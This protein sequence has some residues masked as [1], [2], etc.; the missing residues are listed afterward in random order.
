MVV[1]KLRLSRHNDHDD[2]GRCLIYLWNIHGNP[3]KDSFIVSHILYSFSVLILV[4]FLSIIGTYGLV[5]EVHLKKKINILIIIFLVDMLGFLSNDNTLLFRNILWKIS[6][7]LHIELIP[8]PINLY[9]VIIIHKHLVYRV[10]GFSAA[11]L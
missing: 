3:Q 8:L 10:I 4:F 11:E 2:G 6:I 5:V 1:R 9:F 7:R